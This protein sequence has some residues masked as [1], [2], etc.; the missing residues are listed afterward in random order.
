M[1]YIRKKTPFGPSQ[2]FDLA[3]IAIAPQP[4]TSPGYALSSSFIRRRLGSDPTLERRERT[5]RIS[6]W[7]ALALVLVLPTTGCIFPKYRAYR[8]QIISTNLMA[9][10]DVDL[11]GVRQTEKAAVEALDINAYWSD[12]AKRAGYDPITFAFGREKPTTQILDK[13]HPDAATFKK[14]K[15]WRSKGATELAIIRDYPAELP[16]GPT[17]YRRGFVSLSTKRY[18]AN[19]I[20]ILIQE[21]GYKIVTP[22]RPKD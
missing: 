16:P 18:P 7:L 9:N 21:E 13:S 2:R 10:M 22:E 19:T 6:I 15:S 8:L 14:Y 12:K 3:A 17:D 20:T 4:T 1:N 11:I 5:S